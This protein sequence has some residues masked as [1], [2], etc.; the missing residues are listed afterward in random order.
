ML[1]KCGST[2]KDK[3]SDRD[4]RSFYLL[5]KYKLMKKRLTRQCEKTKTTKNA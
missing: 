3:S 5:K 4:D 2:V 1:Y